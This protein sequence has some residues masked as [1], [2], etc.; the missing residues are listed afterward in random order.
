MTNFRKNFKNKLK[1]R[2]QLF[3]AW[4]SFSETSIT[5]IFS[6]ID[7]DF[8]AIDME[9]STI[10][11]SEAQRIIAAC[12]AR[13]VPC[14]PR[15]VSHSNDYFKPLLESG[16]DGLFI[17]TVNNDEQA[18]KILNNVKYP[19]LGSR[20]YGIN[21]AQAYGLNS[22]K[23]FMNWNDES[24]I[25]FQ[26]ESIEAVENINSLTSFDQVDGIMIGPYDLSGSLG[27]PGQLDHPDLLKACDK[28][29]AAC[30]K[31]NISCGTQISTVNYDFINSSF[32]RGFNFV[33]LGSDL[34]I[35]SNWAKEMNNLISKFKSE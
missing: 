30:V 7:I 34:F 29:I 9:H 33:I 23:Y 14:L 28:V 31:N 22:D 2:S 12:H 21:M 27:I 4:V 1:N 35:L 24:S 32:N 18:K 16:S 11:I 25:I 26:I 13:Q 15:P 19:P 8:L 20:S 5:E 17:S 3:G 6:H 10:S